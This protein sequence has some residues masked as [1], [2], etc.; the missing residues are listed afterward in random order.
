MDYLLLKHLHVGCVVV[1]ASGF[2]A[3]GAGTLIGAQW[4]Q[5]RWVHVVP[6]IVD[7]GLL[8][9]AIAL[10]WSLGVAPV[11]DDWLSA[12]LVGLVVYVL[13]GG[14]ALKRGR[15]TQQKAAAFAA[16]LAVLGY[17]VSVAMTRSPTPWR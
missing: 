11:K 14:I 3:R 9:S 17:I 2:V 13:L 5:Q 10:A 8:A 7:T 4:M 15:T 16:A 12:K 1:S 6:H